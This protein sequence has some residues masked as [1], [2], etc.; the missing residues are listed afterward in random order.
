MNLIRQWQMRDAGDRFSGLGTQSTPREDPY[1]AFRKNRSSSYKTAVC[2]KLLLLFLR[3]QYTSPISL[4]SHTHLPFRICKQ[5]MFPLLAF[6]FIFYSSLILYMYPIHNFHFVYVSNTQLPFCICIQY[7]KYCHM[8][9][10]FNVCIIC[11]WHFRKNRSS[12]YNTAGC[13]KFLFRFLLTYLL[14]TTS[15]FVMCIQYP[16]CFY[17]D[18]KE[19]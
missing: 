3:I 13:A 1:E 15:H 9:T 11:W 6:H 18:I 4:M 7:L 14:Y 5:Y 12:S 17:M 2:A 8:D 10:T 19:C 16:K